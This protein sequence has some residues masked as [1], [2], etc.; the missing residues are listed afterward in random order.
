M[1]EHGDIFLEDHNSEKVRM[2]QYNKERY[3][4]KW[5]E[6][7]PDKIDPKKICFKC[8]N[9]RGEIFLQNDWDANTICYSP[10]MQKQYSVSHKGRLRDII[11]GEL[12]YLEKFRDHKYKIVGHSAGPSS[13][14]ETPQREASSLPL[15]LLPQWRESAC[16]PSVCRVQQYYVVAE[17][18]NK[19]LD[20]FDLN[21]VFLIVWISLGEM[22]EGGY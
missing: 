21:G 5:A 13:H 7:F 3:S 18:R 19:T 14:K 4:Q 10:N 16:L 22:D 8:I 6:K 1:S 20:V 11:D 17:R 2:Y 9:S 12:F 15:T